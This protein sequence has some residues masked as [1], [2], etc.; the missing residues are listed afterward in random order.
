M[1]GMGESQN[2]LAANSAPSNGL[3]PS[4][5]MKAKVSGTWP[6]AV[7]RGGGEKS[8]GELEGRPGTNV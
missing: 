2:Q 1:G 5:Q 7:V 3:G 6:R 4:V 8:H